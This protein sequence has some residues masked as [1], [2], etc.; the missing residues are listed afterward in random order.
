MNEWLEQIDKSTPKQLLEI[1]K[2]IQEQL[3]ALAPNEE[4]K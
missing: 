3:I 1:V 2:N 4:E